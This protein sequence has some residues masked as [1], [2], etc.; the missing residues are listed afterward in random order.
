MHKLNNKL[1]P[2]AYVAYYEI[3]ENKTVSTR[4]VILLLLYAVA[5]TVYT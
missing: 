2:R 4:G 5:I 1:T 3:G